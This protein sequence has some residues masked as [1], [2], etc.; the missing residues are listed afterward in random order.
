M[1]FAE[2]A[3]ELGANAIA[4]M[5]DRYLFNDK[6]AFGDLLM[7]QS[8]YDK[9]VGSIDTAWSAIG[10]YHDLVTPLHACMIAGAIA[11]GGQM[12]EPKLLKSVS[13]GA[14]SGYSL[15]PEVA[16]E[17]ID[18]ATAEELTGMMIACVKSG[19]GKKAAVEGYTVAGKTGTAEIAAEGGNASHAWFVGF[20]ADEGHPICIAVVLERAGS[21]GS[22]AAPVAQKVL[23][24]ALALGY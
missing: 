7:A 6:M 21:G 9:P 19:T 1:Y 23:K 8:V 14:S 20:V 15:S 17:P 3:Q 13:G 12:M 11:N 4:S 2:A 18:R 5:A 10:Q 16:A 24:K 22:H